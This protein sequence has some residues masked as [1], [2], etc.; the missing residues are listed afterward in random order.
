MQL[1]FADVDL[2]DGWLDYARR[3]TAVP[4]RAKLWNET[5]TAIKDSMDC[6]TKHKSREHKE[7][8][9]MTRYGLPWGSHTSRQGPISREFKKLLDDTGAYRRGLSFGTLRH[10]FETV[11]GEALDQIAL[12]F[13]MGHD[14]G[15]MASKY[16]ESVSDERLIALSEHV[17][18]WLYEGGR[19][20]E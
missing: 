18:D 7:L 17:H 15:D 4:R 11:G 6:R 19:N 16:R 5:I 3:K 13:A 14:S 2:D 9:F 20:D 10:Q 12:N 8:I 1:R